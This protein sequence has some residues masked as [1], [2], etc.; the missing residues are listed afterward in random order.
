MKPDIIFI[1]PSTQNKD[2]INQ[3]FVNA[4]KGKASAA[5]HLVSQPSTIS[6][7]PTTF[8]CNFSENPKLF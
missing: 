7:K 2:L 8:K 6:T 1:H 5:F 4:R 3:I